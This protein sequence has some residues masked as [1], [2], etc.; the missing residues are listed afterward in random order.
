LLPL[1][2][3]QRRGNAAPMYYRAMMASPAVSKSL[4]E[5][6]GEAYGE[7]YSSGTPLQDL[8]LDK[9]REAAAAWDSV[10]AELREAS[11]RR[12]CEWDWQ[13]EKIRGPELFA[14]V[15]TEIQ[16]SREL[17]R[18]LMLRVRLALAEGRYDDALA[19]LRI[20][21]KMARDVAAE[22]LL[23]CGL[24]GI[25]EAGIG[26][27]AV[28][29]WIGGP[30][31]PNLYWAL[32]ELPRPL[33]DLREA[34]QFEM[35]G[36]LRAFPL[37][38]DAETAV[39]SPDEWARQLA[40][41]LAGMTMNEQEMRTPLRSLQLRLAGTGIALATYGPAKAR[42]AVSGMSAEQIDAMPVGQVIAIDAAREYRRVADEFEKWWYTPF[43]TAAEHQSSAERTLSGGLTEG[44]YGRMLASLLIPGLQSARTAQERLMWELGGLQTVEALR[45]HAA[46][47]G[48]LP[49][50]LDEIEVVPVPI[51]P[52]TGAHY[53]YTLT[54]GVGVVEL[55]F[56]DG[57]PSVARR[58]EITLAQ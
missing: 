48:S 34:V 37:L 22:P 30:N 57:F 17:T 25:A 19:A 39:L 38:M 33:I 52:A 29:E 4:R 3:E 41:G 43:R 53:A 27:A 28:V 24:V 14:F 40:E 35:T 9:V 45:M 7:W 44:G 6:H 16:E 26:N 49:A 31:S 18:A 46:A 8:P 23:I 11:Q 2:A 42:L 32:A 15:L 54:D 13:L 10:V 55:P 50:K 56:S 1:R 36:V 58:Y 5:K 47:T 20:N 21:Y 51:N 12:D